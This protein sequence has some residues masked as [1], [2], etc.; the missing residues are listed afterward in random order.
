MRIRVNLHLFL[1]SLTH[2]Q[3]SLRT[4]HMRIRVNQHELSSLYLLTCEFEK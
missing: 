3:V 2:R 1:S 4:N